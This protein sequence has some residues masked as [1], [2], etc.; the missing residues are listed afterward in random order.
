MNGVLGLAERYNKMPGA[1]PELTD[2]KRQV[3]DFGGTGTALQSIYIVKWHQDELTGLYPKHTAAGLKIKVLEDQLLPDKN[4]KLL[5]SHVTDY[6]QWFGLKVR[7][8]RYAARVCNIPSDD[9]L[10]DEAAQQMLFEKLIIANNRIHEV[11]GGRVV[12]YVSPDIY[13]MLEIAAFKKSNLALGYS[14]IEG[15]TRVLRFSGIPIRQNDCQS[16]AETAVAA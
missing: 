5:V 4:G 14:A 10:T 1:N 11:S 8:H 16:R 9:I 7:D 12:I 3:V 6:K 2:K 15:D 13:S